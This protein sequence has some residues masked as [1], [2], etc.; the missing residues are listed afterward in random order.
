VADH[1]AAGTAEASPDSRGGARL[2]RNQS[3]E[4]SHLQGAADADRGRSGGLALPSAQNPMMM[5]IC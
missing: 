1:Q 3:P 5:R 2:I 4:I